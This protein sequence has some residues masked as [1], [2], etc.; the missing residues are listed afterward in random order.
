MILDVSKIRGP[1]ERLE[2]TFPADA[3]ASD[4]ESYRV[5]QPVE[6]AADIAKDEDRL[7]LN[8]AVKTLLELR[9]SRCLEPFTVAVNVPFDLRYLPHSRNV[10]AGEVEIQDDD[11]GVAYYR[12]EK[13]DL[14]D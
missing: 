1:R 2:R 3:F 4:D 5:A 7:R 8:G 12:D 10:G 14:G 11:L 6:L 9:C 13:I